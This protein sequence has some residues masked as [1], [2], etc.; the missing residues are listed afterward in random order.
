[1]RMACVALWSDLFAFGDGYARV[2]RGSGVGA[3]QPCNTRGMDLPLI[4][5]VDLTP[6]GLFLAFA[7]L[8]AV[9]Y[10]GSQIIGSRRAHVRARDAEGAAAEREAAEPDA[11]ERD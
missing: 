6:S 10:L 4:G 7:A 8:L 2:R 11:T 5:T 1:M 3:R 9:G